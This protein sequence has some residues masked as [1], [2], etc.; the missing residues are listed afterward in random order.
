MY[1]IILE[2]YTRYA[3]FTPLLY[4]TCQWESCSGLPYIKWFARCPWVCVHLDFC[5]PQTFWLGWVFGNPG[6]GIVGQSVVSFAPTGTRL[7]VLCWD[8]FN[9]A[10][11]NHPGIML[12]LRGIQ[13][14]P[15]QQFGQPTSATPEQKAK[16]A[17]IRLRV[18]L[19]GVATPLDS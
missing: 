12:Y 17:V 10:L 15:N 3:T 9:L 8:S 2:I 14:A 1:Y 13:S 7:I 16:P 19:D 4:D 6:V 5:L 11:T 18:K